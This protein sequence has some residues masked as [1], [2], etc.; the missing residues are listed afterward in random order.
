[1]QKPETDALDNATLPSDTS[2]QSAHLPIIDWKKCL[3][4]CGSDEQVAKR[5]LGAISR[6]LKK[7]PAHRARSL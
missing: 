2:P 5:L 4:A 3:A 6:R 1:M 7:D